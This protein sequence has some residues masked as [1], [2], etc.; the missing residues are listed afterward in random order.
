VQLAREGLDSLVDL[1]VDDELATVDLAISA[2]NSW[3]SIGM[4][5]R[6]RRRAMDTT[7]A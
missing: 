5:S 3:R 6:K 2:E 4:L 7:D 1:G